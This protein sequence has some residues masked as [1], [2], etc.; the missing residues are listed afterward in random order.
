LDSRDHHRCSTSPVL[1]VLASVR[2]ISGYTRVGSSTAKVSED[3]VKSVAEI[4]FVS[5]PSCFVNA[6]GGN[7]ITS[8]SDDPV[9]SVC[10]VELLSSLF[11][12]NFSSL[13]KESFSSLRGPILP[14]T[15]KEGE[16]PRGRVS[17]YI[18]DPSFKQYSIST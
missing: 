17:S 12:D 11:T 2:R 10:V 9:K 5:L 7:R 4:E 8:V 18:N 14:A 3:L 13:S 15:E 16:E 6:E 1:S